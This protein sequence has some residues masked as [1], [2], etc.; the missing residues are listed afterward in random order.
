M[1][2]TNRRTG[3]LYFTF[4]TYGGRRG[5]TDGQTRG[6]PYGGRQATIAQS[7]IAACS[8]ETA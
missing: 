6:L 7:A 5:W 2:Y 4:T 8:I 1:R 3:I